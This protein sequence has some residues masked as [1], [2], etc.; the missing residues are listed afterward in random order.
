[1]DLT[2]D[3]IGRDPAR[4]REL[5]RRT[6]VNIVMGCGHYI[7][8]AHPPG[9]ADRSVSALADEMLRDLCD[10]RDGV[11]AGVIG[12]IGTSDPIDPVER[13]VLLA[14]CQAQRETGRA[15]FVHLDPWGHTG[16]EVLDLCEAAGVPLDRVALVP[17]GPDAAGRRLSSLAGAPRRVDR[18]RHLG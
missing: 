8:R 9:L 5:S 4:L 1:M 13:R 2:L 7:A 3:D 10:G 14:A 11:R 15:L 17:P 6:G 12:E 18:L 16:H